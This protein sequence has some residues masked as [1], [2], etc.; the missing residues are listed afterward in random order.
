MNTFRPYL[1][2]KFLYA[3]GIVAFIALVSFIPI[4]AVKKAPVAPV[5]SVNSDFPSDIFTDGTPA[6]QANLSQAAAFAWNEFIALN[7]PAKSGQRDTPD[8]SLKFGSQGGDVPLVWHTYRHKSEIYPG[9]GKPPGYDASAP[10]FGYNTSSPTYIYNPSD[11]GTSNGE[12]NPCGTASSSTPWINLDEKN[13]I[14]VATMYAGISQ[15]TAY[16]DPQILFL[17]KANKEEYVYAAKNQ[18]W[19]GGTAFDK[20]KAKTKSY[21]KNHSNTPPPDS[22]NTLVSFPNGTVE[23][24]TAWRRLTDEEKASGRF[25]STTV[26]YYKDNGNDKPC[27]VD[28]EFGMLALHIIHKTPTAPYFIY[29]TFEQTD[30]ILTGNGLPVEDVDGTIINNHNLAPTTPALT[31]TNATP[32]TPQMFN[33]TSAH[34]TPRSSLY[35]INVPGYG[36]P[37][38]VFTYNRRYNSIPSEIIASNQMAHQLIADYNS[39][40]GVT[41]SPW[42]YYKLVNVQYKP[43]Q[44]QPG[45]DYTGSDRASYYLSNSVVESDYTLQMFSGQFSKLSND[46]SFTITDYTKSGDVA[47]NAYYN[48]KFLMGGCMGCHGNATN[49]GTDYSFILGNRV[50][51]PEYA[52]PV[53][54]SDDKVKRLM[55][56]IK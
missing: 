53:T 15:A 34:S 8:P 44:K 20:A 9:T 54:L 51:E 42:P 6:S 36:T 11:V 23:I 41:N 14:G 38:G 26:R 19:G 45:V 17:A 2:S 5:I 29:A 7:W 27:Y 50:Q 33:P 21:I 18:W 16:P 13:E 56:V 3:F 46:V 30:N 28:E 39:T 12:V 49:G 25:Y 22:D 47:Y 4:N 43:I 1:R 35:Y 32:T 52:E 24:K 48:G 55:K 31:V 40:N 37:S 10:D